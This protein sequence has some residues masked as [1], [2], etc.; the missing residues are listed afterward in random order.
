MKA[1]I[2]TGVVLALGTAIGIGSQALYAADKKEVYVPPAETKKLVDKPLAT[3]NGKQFT[4][5]HATLKPGFVGGKHY[6]T[7]PVFVYVLEGVFTIDEP[8][9]P[10]QTFKAGQVYEEPIGTPMQA[11]NVSTSETTR[12]LVIQVNN[13]GEPMMYKSD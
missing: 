12:I 10:R 11:F 1:L 8:G 4:I 6:H 3:V 13:Q 9:K 7:G 2:T 5:M